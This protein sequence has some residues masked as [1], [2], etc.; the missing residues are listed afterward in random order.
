M[1]MATPLIENELRPRSAHV[2]YVGPVRSH[3]RNP[4]RQSTPVSGDTCVLIRGLRETDNLPPISWQTDVFTPCSTDDY[5]FV[6]EEN[7]SV[8]A[9]RFDA[10]LQQRIDANVPYV[11]TDIPVN[12]EGA[13]W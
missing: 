12:W 13:N 10:H 1:T 8:S 4:L 3:V 5:N 11:D 2:C 7:V 9:A 6:P